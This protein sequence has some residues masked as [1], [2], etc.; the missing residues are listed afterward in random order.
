MIL[1]HGREADLL[2]DKL[3]NLIKTLRIGFWNDQPEPF[4]GPVIDM[5]AAEK[6]LFAQKG[7]INAGAVPLAETAPS[8]RSRALLSPGLLDVTPVT[9]RPDEEIFGPLLQLIYVEDFDQA[10]R[11]SNK[12]TYGLSAGLISDK[13]EL[14]DRF[15]S[16]VRAGV[17]HWNRP[18]TGASSHLPFGG[19]GQSGNHR[20]GAYFAADYAA[21]PVATLEATKV[22]MP[23]KLPAGLIA[24]TG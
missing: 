9:H 13:P 7:L 24:S 16:Q 15:Q 8:P 23:E 21:Y 2:V 11:E 17:I 12:T 5:A 4:M 19:I 1:V 22:T 20:P 14:F 6:I 10:I 3:L 18:L